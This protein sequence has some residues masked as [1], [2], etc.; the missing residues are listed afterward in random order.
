METVTRVIT[1]LINIAGKTPMKETQLNQRGG[2]DRAL[3]ADK[4]VFRYWFFI[5]DSDLEQVIY[6]L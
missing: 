6:F 5:S 2:E 1:F 3:K 4:P